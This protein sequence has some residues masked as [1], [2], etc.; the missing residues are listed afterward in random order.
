MEKNKNIVLFCLGVPESQSNNT[1]KCVMTIFRLF[2][3]LK[4]I[5][6]V[7]SGT[8]IQQEE[9]E[10]SCWKE[11][12]RTVELQRWRKVQKSAN[13]LSSF[14]SVI[15]SIHICQKISGHGPPGPLLPPPRIVQYVVETGRKEDSTGGRQTPLGSYFSQVLTVTYFNEFH[16]KI[17]KAFWS[18]KSP[19]LQFKYKKNHPKMSFLIIPS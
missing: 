13:W 14:A 10:E 6:T 12:R 4:A 8:I 9:D 2:S 5:V 1:L 17:M 3:T 16:P 11:L 19:K 18:T 15:F 7:S